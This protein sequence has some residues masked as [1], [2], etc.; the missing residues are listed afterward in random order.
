M[1]RKTY[2]EVWL[3]G[4]AHAVWSRWEWHGWHR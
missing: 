4:G 1:E 3:E 2:F